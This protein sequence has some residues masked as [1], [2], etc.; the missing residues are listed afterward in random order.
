ML[1]YAVRD[2]DGGATLAIRDYELAV[3]ESAIVRWL[4]GLGNSAL[5]DFRQGAEREADT[6]EGELWSAVRADAL[7]LI[8]VDA[9]AIH[10]PAAGTRRAS[11]RAAP[12]R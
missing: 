7:A 11:E 3:Q 5:S 4:G 2:G 8:P 10:P 6:F 9:G 12:S 1:G